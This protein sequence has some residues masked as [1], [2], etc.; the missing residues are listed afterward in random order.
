M[1]DIPNSNVIYLKKEI[2]S[3][4]TEV[5]NHTDEYQT[6]GS[7]IY[8]LYKNQFFM[9]ETLMGEFSKNIIN[10]AIDEVNDKYNTRESVSDYTKYVISRIGEPI[11]KK[12]IEERMR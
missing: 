6:F 4:Y 12:L 3:K 10:K 2:G 7:N 11:I 9:D 5:L 8:N 1:S